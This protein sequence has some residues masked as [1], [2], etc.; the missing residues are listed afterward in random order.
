MN[1]QLPLNGQNTRI[2]P[3]TKQHVKEKDKTVENY[4]DKDKKG[5]C[6]R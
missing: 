4:S 5:Q 6:Y 2:D 1:Y 3:S